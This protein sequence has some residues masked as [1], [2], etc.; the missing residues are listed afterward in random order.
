MFYSEAPEMF[1]GLT[2]CRHSVSIKLQN[3]HVLVVFSFKKVLKDVEFDFV[4]TATRF[5]FPKPF[6]DDLYWC[7]CCT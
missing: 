4:Q 3:V 6:K 7:T 2:F 1:F 5:R